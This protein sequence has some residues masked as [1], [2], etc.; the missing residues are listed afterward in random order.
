M[1]GVRKIIGLI[2]KGFDNISGALTLICTFVIFINTVTRYA[3]SKPMN[4]SEEVSVLCLIWIVFLSQGLLEFE[5]NQLCMT[6]LYN[7]LDKKVQRVI[8]LLRSITTVILSSCLFYAGMNTVLR[9]YEFNIRTQ[10]VNF[11]FWIAYLIL[12]L[13]F[14]CIVIIR[15]LDPFAD[16]AGGA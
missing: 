1:N 6:A 3:F 16:K 12:P 4:W 2:V 15:I 11:P 13:I 9:N 5:N 8:N 10:V 7:V 14:V